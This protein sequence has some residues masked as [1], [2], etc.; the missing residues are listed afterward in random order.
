MYYLTQI[1]FL[2]TNKMTRCDKCVAPKDLCIKCREN[3]IYAEVPQYS[4]FRAYNPVCPRGYKDCIS[5]PAYLK[6]Y[7]PAWYQTLYGDLTPVQAL[8]VTNGC[9]D[10]VRKDPDEHFYCYDDEDK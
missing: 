5:D 6:C 4:Q 3:P 2:R 8:E 10:A 7:H 9:M 1:A